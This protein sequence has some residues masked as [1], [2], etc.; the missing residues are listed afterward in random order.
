MSSTTAAL[1]FLESPYFSITA[2]IA[3]A[4]LKSAPVR[5][6]GFEST[7]DLSLMTRIAGSV[8]AVAQ[9][10]ETGQQAA[11]RFGVA[12]VGTRLARPDETLTQLTDFPNSIHPLYGGRELHLPSDYPKDSSNTMAQTKFALGI[13]E[14]QGL[15]AIL[16]ATDAML[17][18]ADVQIVGKEKIGAAY[19]T[20]MI[21]GDVAAVRAALEAGKAAVGD[22]GKL[23][24][25]EV[26]ASPHPDLIALL[27]S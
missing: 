14:T 10:L 27:P 17:K 26:I 3:D 2:L 21:K 20:I 24:A 4:M 23:I 25:A 1:G 22:L 6:L 7:G 15:T 18:A 9:A 12:A 19:V 13:L 8:D 5:L 16:E 11:G